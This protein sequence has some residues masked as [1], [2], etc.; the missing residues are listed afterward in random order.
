MNCSPSA[1]DLSEHLKRQLI[2]LQNSVAAYDNGC[3]EEAI[4]IGVVIRILCHDTQSSVSL[5]KMGQK[6]TLRLVTTA[7]TV[8]NCQVP[9]VHI[10]PV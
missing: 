6:A 9:P 7:K 1:E 5:K 3:A 4:R 2:F 10:R 8:P